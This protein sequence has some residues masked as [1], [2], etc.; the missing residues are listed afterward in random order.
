LSYKVYCGEISRAAGAAFYVVLSKEG[1]VVEGCIL[2]IDL[3][4]CLIAYYTMQ[5]QHAS[6]PTNP[7]G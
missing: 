5:I 7:K 2:I 1:L 3:L 4:K 6:M